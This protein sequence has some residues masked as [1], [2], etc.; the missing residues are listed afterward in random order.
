MGLCKRLATFFATWPATLLLLH[1]CAAD[2]PQCATPEGQYR[3]TYSFVQGNCGEIVN[4]NWVPVRVG[5]RGGSVTDVVQVNDAMVSTEVVMKGCAMRM[6]QQVIK[7]GTLRTKID[8]D[9]IS[10]SNAAALT[11]MV[12]VNRWDELGM[13]ACSGWYNATLTKNSTVV[14]AGVGAPTTAA[15]TN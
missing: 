4:P 11:G 14:G 5:Q 2:A 9:S 6:T 3:P 10:I 8:G 15:G 1:G 12:S 13:P 7:A